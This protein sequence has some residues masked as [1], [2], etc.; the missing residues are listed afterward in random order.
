MMEKDIIINN[1]DV[2][3]RWI[4]FFNNKGFINY[5]GFFGMRL[6]KV[7]RDKKQVYN[8]YFS[9]DNYYTTFKRALRKR[10]LNI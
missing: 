5:T 4:N 8:F 6:I 7:V 1:I 2:L 3:N 9:N 10:E